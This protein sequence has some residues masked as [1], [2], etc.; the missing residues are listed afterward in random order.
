MWLIPINYNQPTESSLLTPSN[1]ELSR[2][3]QIITDFCE[4]HKT[5]INEDTRALFD[6]VFI[7]RKNIFLTGVAG[8]GKSYQL[9]LLYLCS[10]LIFEQRNATVLCSSTGSSALN[11][12]IA[13]A[14]TVHSWSGIM[15][16]DR[17][18]R[19]VVDGELN[20]C[21]DEVKNYIK[22][23]GY[24]IVSTEL[25]F[26][27]EIS[28]IGAFYLKTLDALCKSV[29]KSAKPMGGIQVVFIGDMLQ[30]PPV[31]DKHPF[32]Y[33]VWNHLN[34][35]TYRLTKVYRQESTVWAELLNKIRVA[36]VS[37]R[38]DKVFTTIDTGSLRLLQTRSV[39]NKE[40]IPMHCLWLYSKRSDANSHNHR[41]LNELHEHITYI[42]IAIDS[43][44]AETRNKRLIGE[45]SG[46]EI[47][48]WVTLDQKEEHLLTSKE[49]KMIHKDV[50]KVLKEVDQEFKCKIG[51]R[52]MCK[53]NLHK[54]GGLVNGAR[55]IITD[56]R[57]KET[58]AL[59]EGE[60]TTRT[61]VQA[62]CVRFSSTSVDIHNGC[63]EV[64][65]TNR[66]AN[67]SDSPFVENEYFIPISKHE[68][69][70]LPYEFKNVEYVSNDL[71]VIR[72]RVQ[73][74]FMLAF[75]IT[76]HQSQGLT[77]DDVVIDLNNCFA[78]GQA[79]VAMSRCKSLER[80]HILNFKPSY[81]Y[82]DQ[83]AVKFDS[84]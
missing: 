9:R 15:V 10:K 35:V 57:T 24:R 82:S 66:T 16:E 14:T 36:N 54:S 56:I 3:L 52:V 71:R 28:M 43:S 70:F 20:W 34:I 64:D 53:K 31:K 41:C 84:Q 48:E 65:F 83:I 61:V 76:V 1:G 68:A 79:Y 37:K 32:L 26:I 72:T 4:E 38:G 17:A 29:K 25:I 58:D 63:T 11:I 33:K 67:L 23:P 75:A 59:F 13:D 55:G 81:L 62:I 39:K 47:S 42:S 27:D 45:G 7:Q 22:S 12:G 8:T 19:P 30:L 46:E 50:G 78:P 51:A 18:Q 21:E 2:R 73:F 69:W 74:P 49:Q 80:M 6:L 5:R 60:L 44:Y 77:L 40:D